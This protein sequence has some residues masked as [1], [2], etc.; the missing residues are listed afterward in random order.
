MTRPVLPR[1]S[2][3]ILARWDNE[4][5]APDTEAAQAHDPYANALLEGITMRLVREYMVGPYCYSDLT[6]AIAERNRRLRGSGE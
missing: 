3:Q 2:E 1:S 5:G 6:L 4:G